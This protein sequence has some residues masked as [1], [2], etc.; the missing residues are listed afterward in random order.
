M[1]L[2]P[3][4]RGEGPSAAS[5]SRRLPASTLLFWLGGLLLF[6]WLVV[7][8]ATDDLA[9]QI[10]AAGWAPLILAAYHFLPL[11]ADAL[12][13][14]IL[15]PPGERPRGLPSLLWRW[16]LEAANALV[17]GGVVAGEAIRIR[18]AVKA[19]FGLA[20]SAAVLVV[21][22]TLAALAQIAF[23]ILGLVVLL[24]AQGGQARVLAQWLG[25]GLALVAVLCVAAG[26]AQRS[27][28]LGRFL[29]WVARK[30]GSRL[31]A[32]HIAGVRRLDDE[33]RAIHDR[34]RALFSAI[35]MKM[36]S[37]VVGAGEV[38][39]AFQLLDRPVSLG[40][41]L[42]MESL[43]QAVRS[44]AFVVPGG[45]GV[46]EAAALAV[47][48]ALGLHPGS[49]FAYALLRRL[50]EWLLGLGGLVIWQA[51]EGRH[52]RALLAGR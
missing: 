43:V 25:F 18:L 6:G 52:L 1:S 27:G 41:A 16:V 46:Q 5:A 33:L 17:P 23:S 13:W 38:Y 28:V 49:T 47:G 9:A 15:F 21:D 14:R 32:R 8:A 24:G 51:C 42:I 37:W 12:S 26:M 45:L 50:R 3:N 4:P 11:M 19:G 7:R 31:A 2:D 20:R 10:L 36:F 39:I 34:P 48:A 30:A 29:D 22:V 35:A 40:E 44:A